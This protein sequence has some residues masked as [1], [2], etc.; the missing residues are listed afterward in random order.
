[1]F[2][3]VLTGNAADWTLGQTNEPAFDHTTG[4]SSGKY[5][6][7]DSSIM[8][9]STAAELQSLVFAEESSNC[10]IRSVYIDFSMIYFF[11]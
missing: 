5:V 9:G 2:N 10:F 1:M 4:Q 6:Y 8:D 7:L 3:F 11:S